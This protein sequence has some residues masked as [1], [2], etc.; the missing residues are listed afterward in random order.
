MNDDE[1]GQWL[2]TAYRKAEGNPPSFAATVAGADEA[3]KRRRRRSGGL[4]GLA[5]ALAAVA[6][7]VSLR[8]DAP[9]MP[10]NEYLIADALLNS[11]TWSAPSDSLM[12]AHQFDIYREVLLPVPSTNLREGSLL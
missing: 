11:T 2:K 3:M 7:I 6:L 1:L 12:P 9:D 8:P 4:A 10:S 5:A